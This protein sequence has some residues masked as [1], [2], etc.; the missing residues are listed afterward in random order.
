VQ[1]HMVGRVLILDRF[2][3]GTVAQPQAPAS[4]ARFRS[5]LRACASFRTLGL[6][7]Y[8]ARTGAKTTRNPTPLNAPPGL[9]PFRSAERQL[10]AA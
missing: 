7:G 6:T 2:D 1:V 4:G 9:Q 8:W 10:S 5:G 3:C